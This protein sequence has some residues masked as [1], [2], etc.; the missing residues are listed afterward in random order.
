MAEFDPNKPFEAVQQFD[1][2]K[3]FEVVKEPTIKQDDKELSWGEV[4]KEAVKN[5]IPSGA[6]AAESMV[7]PF[8]HPIDTAKNIGR[9]GMGVAQKTGVVS[10]TSYIPYA[11]ALE[12]LIEQ[13]YGSVGNFKRTF[14]KDPVGVAMDAS[15]FLTG[16]ETALARAPGVV[17]KIGEAAG[18]A[19]RM[20]DPLTYAGKAAKL[21][22]TGGAKLAGHII[23]DLGIHTGAEPLKLAAR[24]GYEGGDAAKSFQENLRG[25]VPVEGAVEEAQAALKN[26][27]NERGS[28]YRSGMHD[29]SKDKTV[30][31]FSDVDNAVNNIVKKFK[32]VSISKS[33]EDVQ[34][35]IRK[36][37]EDWKELDPKE[38]HTP[39]GLDALK[40]AIG[41]V[42]A[43]EEHGSPARLAAQKV[44]HAVRDTI[45]KQAPE[46]ARIMKGYDEASEQI[47]EIEKTLSL[48]PKASVDTALRKLQ[49]ILRDNV[50]TSYGRRK[51]LAEFLVRSGAKNLMYK[52]AGQALQPTFARSIGR[53]GAQLGAEIA[54]M[55]AGAGLLTGGA[56]LPFMSPR[57]MG[58]A[59]YYGGK[60][61]KPVSKIPPRPVARSFFQIG[62]LQSPLDQMS[63][64]SIDK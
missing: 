5:I 54:L 64:E 45:V 27:K 35:K 36:I 20:V 40:Q 21:A 18:A 61:A 17:G 58:E 53:L 38:Y 60:I 63:E 15:M 55:R 32:N 59:A 13:R 14:A 29:I 62:R 49:S 16:G 10:G 47:R 6:S 50:N 19:G 37:V 39:E 7:Q 1:P 8:I 44:Y 57:A 33:T 43:N 46:Y 22:G 2:N 51:E 31:S 12:Q 34:N 25:K 52:L 24:A 28:E 4:G 9:L 42:M 41:D 26:M 48:N 30:L 56:A 11:N 3:P 23:G